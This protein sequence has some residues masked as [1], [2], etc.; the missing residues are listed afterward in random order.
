[1]L[2]NYHAYVAMGINWIKTAPRVRF[3][4]YETI[5]VLCF[6]PIKDKHYDCF[7]CKVDKGL[8]ASSALE[9]A[10]TSQRFFWCL[11][12]T[13][14]LSAWITPLFLI[15]QHCWAFTHKRR[16]QYLLSAGGCL[17]WSATALWVGSNRQK[18]SKSPWE[19]GWAW[20]IGLTT[21]PPPWQ[22]LC[23]HREGQAM[24]VFSTKQAS[25]F[26]TAFELSLK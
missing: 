1:M 19:R 23:L 14:E 16:L 20:F 3:V 25:T 10:I 22:G 17:F 7:W 21:A 15:F 8:S 4:E 6:C 18:W 26:C 9:A 12:A 2:I 24:F 5:F 11:V 13:N